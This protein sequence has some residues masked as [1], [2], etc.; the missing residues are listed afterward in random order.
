MSP[1]VTE[2]FVAEVKKYY[3]AQESYTKLL[4]QSMNG[5]LAKNHDAQPKRR[6]ADIQREHAERGT[7][8]MSEFSWGTGSSNEDLL[9]AFSKLDVEAGAGNNGGGSEE[10]KT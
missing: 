2:E 10:S 6:Y 4:L 1:Q 9:E 7:K 8:P 3:E 5:E